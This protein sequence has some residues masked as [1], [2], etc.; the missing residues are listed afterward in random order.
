MGMIGK[1]V[2]AAYLLGAMC[3]VVLFT[4]S[5]RAPGE[6]VGMSQVNGRCSRNSFS[7]CT[8][9]NAI[10]QYRGEGKVHQ[11]PAPAGRVR[12]ENHPKRLATRKVGDRVTVFYSRERP[13]YGTVVGQGIIWF[14]LCLLGIPFVYLGAILVLPKPAED[15]PT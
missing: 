3:L 4:F 14:A 11:V 7:Q 8:H 2:A 9:F 10:V 12:G 13:E 6:V 1:F 5:A 15:G